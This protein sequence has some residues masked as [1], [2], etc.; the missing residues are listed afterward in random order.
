MERPHTTLILALSLDGKIA[1][2]HQS[3]ARF[4]SAVDQQHLERSI[5]AAD[6][7]LLGAG[8]LRAY[9]SS[10]PVRDPKLLAQ[11]SA[12]HRPPQPVQILCSA[13]GDLD[14]RWRFFQQPLPRWLLTTATGADRWAV[15]PNA[16][17]SSDPAFD[18]CFPLL[19]G[20]PSTW[21]WP[22]LLAHLG[23]AL[24]QALPETSPQALP[25]PLTAASPAARSLAVLGG[26]TLATALIEQGCID[27]LK[28][29]LCP[30]LLGGDMAPSLLRGVGFG[31]SVAPRLQLL[32]L[33]TVADEIFL[34][35]RVR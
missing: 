15:Q 6:A 18:R 22:T 34:H 4:G 12:Q 26:A 13:S 23:Q 31:E 8:T 25:R 19:T 35:Y 2:R 27:E 17:Y 20:A 21:H 9:H 28:L 1:D 24:D 7:V 14:P 3:P 29:T 33:E 5:A 10:L 16:S 11:R 32:N 30:L